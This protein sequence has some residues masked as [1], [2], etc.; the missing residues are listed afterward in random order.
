VRYTSDTTK[1]ALDLQEKQG[2]KVVSFGPDFKKMA[3]DLYWDDLKKLSPESI[4]KL[5]ALLAK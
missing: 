1:A 5:Q 4:G 2:I 3:V